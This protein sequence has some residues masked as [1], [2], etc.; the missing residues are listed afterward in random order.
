METQNFQ[1]SPDM[2]RN[3]K[4]LVCDQC[5]CRYFEPVFG[6]KKVSKLLVMRPKDVV[7]PVQAY[8]CINCGKVAIDF[9]EA[10]P[11]DDE[12]DIDLNAPEDDEQQ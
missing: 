10:E 3:A 9:K 5:E 1:L 7:V 4:D 8:R 11:K 6:F 12:V 2:V